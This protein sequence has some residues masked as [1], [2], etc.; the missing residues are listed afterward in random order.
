ML[1]MRFPAQIDSKLK[2]G[3]GHAEF[4]TSEIQLTVKMRLTC[5]YHSA[6]KSTRV[7]AWIRGIL[8]LTIIPSL[9][10]IRSQIRSQRAC[11]VRVLVTYTNGEGSI[12]PQVVGRPRPDDAP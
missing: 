11:T 4:L 1:A 12:S 9:S 8:S 10:A 3:L 5:R 6:N 7:F 2:F